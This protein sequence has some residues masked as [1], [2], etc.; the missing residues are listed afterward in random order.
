[1]SYICCMINLKEDRSNNF[2][3]VLLMILFFFLI[4]S[5]AEKSIGHDRDG[6]QSKFKT[7][8]ELSAT[9]TN[10][11]DAVQLFVIQKSQITIIDNGNFIFFSKDL[12][13]ISDNKKIIQKFICQQQIQQF[14]KPIMN[15]RYYDHLFPTGDD[16]V[17]ILS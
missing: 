12:K 14:I 16:E 3:Q 6:N 13:V 4:T 17:P 9:N 8:V 2:G 7:A 10:V 5:F 15:C 11:A 1:M